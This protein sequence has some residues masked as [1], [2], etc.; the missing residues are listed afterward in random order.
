MDPFP[1][2]CFSNGDRDYHLMHPVQ[3]LPVVFLPCF[4]PVPE[5]DEAYAGY[6]FDSLVGHFVVN[7][8]AF[9]IFWIAYAVLDILL[10][11]M[12]FDFP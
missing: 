5:F 12:A 2:F 8:G 7:I 10:G 3:E 9:L 11:G 6:S 1:F 4:Q